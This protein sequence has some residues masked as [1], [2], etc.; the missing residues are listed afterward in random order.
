[1]RELIVAIL[2][3]MLDRRRIRKGLEMQI[4]ENPSIKEMNGLHFCTH[5]GKREFC[6]EANLD[7][8]SNS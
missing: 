1:M 6:D 8:A 5:R 4:Q 7:I 3:L 2:V